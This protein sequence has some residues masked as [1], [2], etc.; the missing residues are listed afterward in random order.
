MT[1]KITYILIPACMTFSVAMANSLSSNP[2]LLSADQMDQVSAGSGATVDV[3]ATGNSSF[4]AITH[5]NAAAQTA[6]TNQD[7]PALAGYAEIAGGGAV[8]VA[9]GQGATTSTTVSPTTS[10]QGL[11]GSNTIQAD[12]HFKSSLIEVQA[13]IIYTSGSLFVNPL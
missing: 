10:S 13:N 1:K 4:F 6:V 8:A 2:I 5:T 3:S 7:T 11:A 12:G 9:A